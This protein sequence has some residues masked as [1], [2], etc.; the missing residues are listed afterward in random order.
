MGLSGK[1][2]MKKWVLKDK[3]E[4]EGRGSQCAGGWRL[5]EHKTCEVQCRIPWQEQSEGMGCAEEPQEQSGF[6]HKRV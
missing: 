5:V 1:D 4:G 6:D 3:L 2:M